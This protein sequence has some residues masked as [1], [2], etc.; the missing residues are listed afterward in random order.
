M[1][2]QC[3]P[4][5]S[6]GGRGLGT[7]LICIGLETMLLKLHVKLVPGWKLIRVNLDP[8][9]EIGSKDGGRHSFARGHSFVRLWCNNNTKISNPTWPCPKPYK[10]EPSSISA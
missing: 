7:R 5:L 2:K 9:Q 4:G 6:S 1:C 10:K 8:I 3:V